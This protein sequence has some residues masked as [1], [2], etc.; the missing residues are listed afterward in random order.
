M[1][2][3]GPLTHANCAR[4]SKVQ[5]HKQSKGNKKIHAEART[6]AVPL[7]PSSHPLNCCG[8]RTGEEQSAAKKNGNRMSQRREAR[9]SGLGALSFGLGLQ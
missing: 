9:F 1:T 4:K 7:C 5:P 3:L 2:S 8:Q 6:K